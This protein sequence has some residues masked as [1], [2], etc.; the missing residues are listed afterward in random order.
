MKALKYLMCIGCVCLSF[1][2]Q[3]QTLWHVDSSS[4]A[5]SPTGISWSSALTDLQDALDSAASGDTIWV[6]EGTYFADRGTGS[7][8]SSFVMRT[9]VVLLGGFSTAND[10]TTLASRDWTTNLTILSGELQADADSS[11]NTYIIIRNNNNSLTNSAELNGFIVAWANNTNT[12][13]GL[14]EGGG[15]FNLFASPTVANCTFRNNTVYGSTGTA[16]GAGIFNHQ[17][18]P[19]LTN[20]TFSYNKVYCNTNILSPDKAFGGAIY[21]NSVSSPSITNCTFSYNEANGAQFARGGA[22][23]NNNS[24]KPVIK[25]SSFTYNSC[26][27]TRVGSGNTA[28]GAAVYNQGGGTTSAMT[29]CLMAN[30]SITGSTLGGFGTI[31]YGAAICNFNSGTYTIAHCTIANNTATSDDSRGGAMWNST[32]TA[33]TIVN[34]VI[35]GNTATTGANIRN[36]GATAPGISYSDIEGCGGSASW[37]SACGTDDGN[38]IDEDP[39]FTDDSNDDFTLDTCSPAFNTGNISGIPSGTTTDLNGNQRIQADSVDMGAY[40]KDA[41]ATCLYTWDGSTDTDWNTAA[42]WNRNE[43]PP[44]YAAI[45]IPNVTNQPIL[46]SIRKVGTLT[47]D[48]AAELTLHR[49]R[50]QVYGNLHLSGTLN[51][52][53]SCIEM[54][55]EIAQTINGNLII[56]TLIAS[57]T[58]G[59][60]LSGGKTQIKV[61]LELINGMFNT[62]DSLVLL[63]DS[64]GTARIAEIKNDAS[65]TGNVTT[66]QYFAGDDNNW[67]LI[68]AT[69]KNNTLQHWN[70]DFITTGFPGSD[71]PS[72]GWINLYRY[73]ETDTGDFNN[74]FVAPDTITNIIGVAQGWMVYMGGSS[75]TLDMTGEVNT[76]TVN[77]TL[78]YTNNASAAN[79]GWNLIGNPMPS[80]VDFSNMS[81]VRMDSAYYIYDPATSNYAS[82]NESTGTGSLGA[83]GNIGQGQ[84]FWVHGTDAF[85]TLTF[86]ETSKTN[87]ASLFFGKKKADHLRMALHSGTQLQDEAIIHLMPGSTPL[88]DAYDTP[89]LYNADNTIA[90]IATASLD[91]EQLVINSI[92][93]QATNMHIPI[94]LHGAAGSNLTIEFSNVNVLSS[95]NCLFLEDLENDKLIALTKDTTYAVTLPKSGENRL[96]QLL[97]TAPPKVLANVN[98]TQLGVVEELVICENDELTLTATGENQSVFDWNN[99]LQ[100]GISFIPQA[101]NHLF[102]VEE[103]N[104]NTGCKL[105]AT[106]PVLVDK[107][108][109]PTIKENDQHL[110]T[111][112]FAAYQW[113]FNEEAI[114]GATNQY[115]EAIDTGSYHVVVWNENGCEGASGYFKKKGGNTP[116]PFE[117]MLLNIYPNPGKLLRLR[118]LSSDEETVEITVVDVMGKTVLTERFEQTNTLERDYELQNAPAGVYFVRFKSNTTERIVRWVK[119]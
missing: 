114:E 6:A 76:G 103:S 83:D 66:Q 80:P 18:S 25:N 11:N 39:L 54:R 73:N 51:N 63:S 65:I 29:N 24:S 53:T 41:S 117:G 38:N 4:A 86:N 91:E 9:G 10:D 43:V 112:Q 42:N 102:V 52:D 58:G 93:E 40:E 113:Y 32:T 71:Y 14:T 97:I 36:E 67:R 47:L 100:N 95:G 84:A 96:L 110:E 46:D 118:Y 2:I 115:F 33:P 78:D 15:M 70:D 26:D 101:G 30:N 90:A 60:T 68:S 1:V 49:N 44:A 92:G 45:S 69:V 22:I 7:R 28:N 34:S 75:F 109:E 81:S 99:G 104:S 85:P 74:G 55:S 3:A 111:E 12:S 77:V 72:F 116:P 108:P 56:D 87:S 31:A 16:S 107:L 57:G 21:N 23:Y 94:V 19:V 61:E 62:S 5:V 106:F 8:D 27:I 64:N 89:K 79:I 50:L 20:C 119:Q 105:N 35:Y 88:R 17:S 48:S 98:G 82:W 13:G 59:V 37:V